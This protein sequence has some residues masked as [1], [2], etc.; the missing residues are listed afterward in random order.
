MLMHALTATF[1]PA[2]NQRD[3]DRRVLRLETQL[4]I[5]DARQ[6]ALVHNLSKTGM[7]VSA[8]SAMTVGEKFEIALP[9]GETYAAEIVWAD[10][11]LFGCRFKTP[12]SQSVLSAAL[13]RSDPTPTAAPAK[14]EPLIQLERLRQYWISEASDLASGALATEKLPLATRAWTI[15][16]LAC[17][18]WVVVTAGAYL[19]G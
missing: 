2:S 12:L 19:I 17:A 5:E 16:G 4:T 14:P 3:A 6:G 10:E 9:D 1:A 15:L 7:L 13:L 8:D 11:G 18:A